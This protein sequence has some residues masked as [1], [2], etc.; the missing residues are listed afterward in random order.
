MKSLKFEYDV[1][2][3]M[4][5]LMRVDEVDEVGMVA[6]LVSL[7]GRSRLGNIRHN[8]Y[9]NIGR[10][11][12]VR[13]ENIFFE[14]YSPFIEKERLFNYMLPAIAQHPFSIQR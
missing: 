8:I 1:L 11:L 5:V 2:Q 6:G 4:A 13:I 14:F 7:Y 12:L 10:E 9:T 3:N